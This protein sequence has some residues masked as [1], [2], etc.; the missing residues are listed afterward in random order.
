MPRFLDLGGILGNGMPVLRTASGTHGT[1]GRAGVPAI[2]T[3]RR[4]W[5]GTPWAEEHPILGDRC[6]TLGSET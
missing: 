3:A 5:M 4:P 2:A 6:G 1:Q